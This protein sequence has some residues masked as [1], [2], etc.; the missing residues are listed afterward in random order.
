M[1]RIV[2]Q[3]LA[4][5]DPASPATLDELF[6]QGAFALPDGTEILT[7]DQVRNSLL[8]LVE[9]GVAEGELQMGVRLSEGS[10]TE[11]ESEM[12]RGQDLFDRVIAK[13]LEGARGDFV[14]NRDVFVR[15]V[16]RVF[17]DLGEVY[18]RAI[19][20][21]LHRIDFARGP[22]M[23][24]VLEA[25][26]S[27]ECDVAAVKA[28]LISFIE[29]VTP[30]SAHV[31]WNL[32]QNYYVARALGLDA[33]GLALSDEVFGDAEIYLD[34]NVAIPAL[35]PL[36]RR[37]RDFQALWGACD[38][39]AA[40]LLICSPTVTEV[41]TSVGTR[42]DV[43]EKV[44]DEVP[45]ELEKRVRDEFFHIARERL[46]KGGSLDLEDVFS[47]YEDP[48]RNLRDEFGV[49][50]VDDHW[51]DQAHRAPA[52]EDLARRV[53][54]AWERRTG[55]PKSRLVALHDAL[56]LAWVAKR[57]EEIPDRTVVL[58]TR[59]HTLPDVSFSEGERPRVM[60]LDAF[61]QWVSPLAVRST[62]TTDFSAIFAEAIK[63]ELLPQENFFDPRDFLVFREME[64]SC[65]E[66]P[67]EDVEACLDHIK[68]N[69]GHLDPRK[70][71]HRERLTA[72]I[73]RFMVTPGRKY[74]V[75]LDRLDK[76][77]AAQKEESER[78]LIA[79][80]EV[81]TRELREREAALERKAQEVRILKKKAADR[82]DASR[83]ENLRRSALRRTGLLLVAF[84]LAEGLLLFGSFSGS[85]GG[86]SVV[87]TLNGALPLATA[88]LAIFVV[89]GW[90][91]LG[92]DR[93]RALGW[94]AVK[95]FKAQ[96]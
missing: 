80:R 42:R 79:Q 33:E 89:L 52:I 50:L 53:S 2:S 90:L 21:D 65:K 4:L 18:V 37:H 34:T 8:R 17:A 69:M 19:L 25:V 44:I 91:C 23:K 68:K 38:G 15:A 94:S 78:E 1:D 46:R 11:I 5:S 39:V 6:R 35:A 13:H 66:L 54:D 49:E 43:L 75:D 62:P 88:L 84:L 59:D 93:I 87:S 95:I 96:D 26:D 92:R 83:K 82:E 41:R 27:E 29:D 22:L 10:R 74:L 7:P 48:A 56:L 45:E 12:R 14:R 58:V 70:A 3:A 72:E 55:R 30:D 28:G 24:K 71:E 63:Y 32:A 85:T 76:E 60:M 73:N 47:P 81:A 86:Q 31:K 57:R 9:N 36:N 67:A 20:G 77:K 61:I 64:M 51:F 16:A 40:N